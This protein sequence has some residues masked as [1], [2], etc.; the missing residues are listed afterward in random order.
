MSSTG[1]YVDYLFCPQKVF[2]GDV[3]TWVAGAGT[4]AAAG[5]ALWLARRSD[6]KLL[7]EQEHAAQVLAVLTSQEIGQI[8][9]SLPPIRK[10][11]MNLL[12]HENAAE[13]NW[14]ALARMIAS[15]RL[16]ILESS[17][18]RVS[19]LHGDDAKFV[20][21]TLAGLLQ[22]RDKASPWGRTPQQMAP[23]AQ[24]LLEPLLAMAANLQRY[25]NG[26]H[27][28]VWSL[29]GFDNYPINVDSDLSDDEKALIEDYDRRGGYADPI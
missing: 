9:V 4:L 22:L 11:L 17:P 12:E 16:P 2:W 23:D 13:A 5:I 7:R 25:V 14:P 8:R 3:A 1:G 18:E 6:S 15:L 24:H 10:F 21:S 20:A 28:R 26:A 19:I 29:A 27:E